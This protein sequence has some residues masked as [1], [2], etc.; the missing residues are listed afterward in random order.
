MPLWSQVEVGAGII[1]ASLPSL[2][3]LVKHLWD[4]FVTGKD[5]TPSYI[6]A[7]TKSIDSS[8]AKNILSHTQR[9]M[10]EGD[11]K[12]KTL[13]YDACEGED[14]DEEVSRSKPEGHIGLAFTA[15]RKVVVERQDSPRGE[16]V[17]D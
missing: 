11:A 14:V 12:G 8:G 16:V 3:P 7:R 2:S 5:T 10:N 6:H 13:F 9:D 17:G 1:A 4:S 15:D